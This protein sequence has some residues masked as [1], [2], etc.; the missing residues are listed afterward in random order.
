MA[1]TVVRLTRSRNAAGEPVVR[2]GIRLLDE[3]LQFLSGQCRPNTVLAVAYDRRVFFTVVGKLPRRVRSVDVLAFMTAQRTGG[4]GR[5]QV[6]EPG[7]AGVSARPLRRRL[8]PSAG[9]CYPMRDRQAAQIRGHGVA[10]ALLT[11]KPPVIV[12]Y[13]HS[14]I[15]LATDEVGRLR[16]GPIS[17]GC[18]PSCRP[19]ASRLVA[20]ARHV[21]R[22]L[23]KA[24]SSRPP[25]VRKEIALSQ[26]VTAA[27]RTKYSSFAAA[28]GPTRRVLPVLPTAARRTYKSP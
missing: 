20:Q 8:P 15:S 25:P 14:S 2:L 28:V 16:Y 6:A 17:P 18:N 10:P 13:S 9:S 19:S 21:V 3:Y 5:L 22:C 7:Q 26:A 11:P 24:V 23:R 1:V 27:G 12:A 4:D